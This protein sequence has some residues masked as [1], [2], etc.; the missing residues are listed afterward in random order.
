MIRCM[1]LNFSAAFMN[2]ALSKEVDSNKVEQ[3]N[4]KTYLARFIFTYFTR[5]YSRVASVK[6]PKIR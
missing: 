6:M 2:L 4:Y 3:E 5:S 1:V